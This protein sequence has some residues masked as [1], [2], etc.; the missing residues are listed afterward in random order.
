MNYFVIS[1]IH[2][3][4]EKLEKLL[5]YWNCDNQRLVFLG[6]YIDRGPDSLKVL[7]RIH[8]LKEHYD[9]IV[10]RGNHEEL[11]LTWFHEPD[12]PDDYYFHHVGLTTLLSFLGDLPNQKSTSLPCI[13]SSRVVRNYIQKAYPEIVQ[14]IKDTKLYFETKSYIFVHAGFNPELRN[15]K[16]STEKDYL[17][18]RNPFIYRKNETGKIAIFGHTNTHILHDDEDNNDVWIDP[19]KSKVG[20]DGG[21]GN[22][23]KLNGVV[24]YE[25]GD[26]KR[27]KTFQV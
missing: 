18:I 7:K 24:L 25:D 4:A 11:F 15:W 3:H 16:N 26:L 10:N 2:G 20:I 5:H 12:D 14:L 17:W 19:W 6:D 23:R 22:G 21:A 27:M 8:Y 13:L 9:A 1:D